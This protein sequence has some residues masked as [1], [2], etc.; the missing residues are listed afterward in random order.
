[1]SDLEGMCFFRR[2]SAL[3]PADVHAE[4]FLASIPDGREVL[5]TIRRPR[6]PQNHRHFFALLRKACDHMAEHRR[7]GL[8]VMHDEDELLDALKLAVGHVQPRQRIDGTVIFVPK[9]I[10][11]AS[12]PEDA[13]KRFKNRSLYVLGQLLG[14]DP[15]EL[16]DDAQPAHRSAA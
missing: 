16:M 15:L 12:M 6:S 7:E 13:F 14:F 9:S 11:F 8:P 1:M 4:E 10:D 2:G 3:I 5:V